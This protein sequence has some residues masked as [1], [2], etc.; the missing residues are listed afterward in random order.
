MVL[1][2]GKWAEILTE[3][4]DS[5]DVSICLSC[6]TW[7]EKK[8]VKNVFRN[9]YRQKEKTESGLCIFIRAARGKPAESI[10]GCGRDG[11]S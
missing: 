6:G 4:A 2:E 1:L 10:S 7:E 11:R 8:R 5:C 9:E 3:P